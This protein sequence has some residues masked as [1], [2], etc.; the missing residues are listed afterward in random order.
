LASEADANKIIKHVRV[1]DEES[2]DMKFYEEAKSD[3]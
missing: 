1:S 3:V 2:K